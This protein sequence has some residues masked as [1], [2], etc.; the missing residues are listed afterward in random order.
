M[1]KTILLTLLYVCLIPFGYAQSLKG[2]V[3][4]AK[5]GTPLAGVTVILNN[6]TIG[7]V[8]DRDGNYTIQRIATGRYTVRYSFVG[9]ETVVQVMDLKAN[10]AQVTNISLKPIVMLSDEVVI[11]GSRR[12][13]KLL[14]TP[15]SIETINAATLNSTGGGTF[16][17]ALAN[18]KGVDF[19]NV[20]INGQGISARGFS[21]QFNTRML[22]MTDGRLSQLPGTG[23]P[24]G[25]LSSTSPLD[26]KAIEVVVGPASALYGPN[27]HAGVVNVITKSP[28][29]QSGVAI[30]VRGGQQSLMDGTWRIA[31]TVKNQLGFKLNGQYMTAKDFSPDRNAKT[32]YFDAA[33][34][35]FEA[36]MLTNGDYDIKSFKYDGTLYYRVGDWNVQAGYGFAE[37]TGFGLT[38]AGRNHI[39]NWQVSSVTASVNNSHFYGQVTQT[40]NDAGGTY[41]LNQLAAVA[42][43]TPN[44]TPAGLDASRDALKFIDLGK[45]L[46]SEVQYNNQF[47]ALKLITGFQY[48]DYAPNSKG[49]FL[50]D[51]NGEDISATE[52][53]GYMQLDLKI[54]G[55]KLR[56][57][58][59]GRYDKHSD[60]EAQF[61][62]KAALVF[63]PSP[64]H[65]FRAGYNH[66]FKSPTVLENNLFIPFRINAAIV[67]NLLG[68]KDGFVLKDA[69]GK[70]VATIDPLKPEKVDGYEVGYKGLFGKKVY[71]DAVG[72]YSFYENFISPLKTVANGIAV[73]PYKADG[74]TP[75]KAANATYNGLQ[76]YLNFGK[77]EIWGVDA[78]VNVYATDH[79]NLGFSVSKIKL[80]KATNTSTFVTD[81]LI[82]NVPET[83][84]KANVTLKDV[85]TKGLFASLS[86]RNTSAYAFESGYWSAK[87]FFPTSC[88]DATDASTC[89]IPA[90]TTADV[91]VGYDVPKLGAS[92]KLNVSNITDDQNIDVLGAPIQGRFIW[93]GLGYNFNGFKF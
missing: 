16:L 35:V 21:S 46:D 38:N 74:V 87:T 90:R 30:A 47:G 64:A 84:L 86:V 60:Y 79:L 9:Y 63:S 69:T 33:K 31:G 7:T 19:V 88:T 40:Q 10:Q 13:E 78:G 3:T 2:R 92:I 53:G 14:D 81:K 55:D 93:L 50:A 17:S 85:G 82:L 59:A 58:G 27:A 66:A 80:Q 29:D 76:T 45:L 65:H 20:G 44:F 12:E 22:G 71:F 25:N 26:V 32:H 56:F 73:V 51:A 48:R 43:A 15:A 6:T 57:V 36:D 61:S 11:S 83:K 1:K 42:A 28:W 5:G 49:T 67:Y 37:N 77:A 23:L 89:R 70:Q 68:N 91:V 72:Y 34:K 4:D 54:L 52:Y 18:L 75:I 41:Q 24:Q 39:R 8:T 62:P